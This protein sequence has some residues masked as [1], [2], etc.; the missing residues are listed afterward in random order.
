MAAQKEWS[1]RP[2]V[3]LNQA[4]RRRCQAGRGLRTRG[5]R[6]IVVAV[7][8]MVVYVVVEVWSDSRRRVS[9]SVGAPAM[10]AVVFYHRE[11]GGKKEEGA[12]V[13]FLLD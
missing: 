8:V 5:G 10:S 4:R 11:E 3:H 13:P 2:D 6:G 7:A 9:Y 12:I 1:S